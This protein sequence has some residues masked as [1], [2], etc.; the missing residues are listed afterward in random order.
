MTTG[1]RAT[2]GPTP[3][4]IAH[5]VRNAIAEGLYKPGDHISQVE[6]AE[7]FNVSRIPLREALRTLV[8]EGLL[9]NTSRRGLSVIQLDQ[10]RINEIYD[11]R[12]LVEPSFAP[13]IIRHVSR[14][15]IERFDALVQR[16]E[17]AG[18]EDP[19]LWSQINLEFHLEQYALAQL[20]VRFEMLSRLYYLLEP[21]SRI[22]V[23]NAAGK[24]RC[25][26]EHRLLLQALRDGDADLY[27]RTIVEHM[28]GAQETLVQLIE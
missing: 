8:S 12:R 2:S 16:M 10:A 18:A 6:L 27:A 14:A 25:D 23:H 3:D 1:S 28:V 22:Y 7:R 26:R 24:D 17:D 21:Y 19:D 4:E 9:E 11:L 13:S 20:P 5:V 15:D